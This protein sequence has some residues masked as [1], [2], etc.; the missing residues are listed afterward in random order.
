MWLC[1]RRSILPALIKG[2]STL[3]PVL[4]TLVLLLLHSLGVRSLPLGITD[5][6]LLFFHFLLLVFQVAP[7]FLDLF[8]LFLELFVLGLE[9]ACLDLVLGFQVFVFLLKLGNLL[10]EFLFPFFLFI[11]FFLNVLILCLKEMLPFFEG[12]IPVL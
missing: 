12:L 3:G 1:D 10:V 5:G 7:Q 2:W 4:L 8:P 9:R 11:D 6:L